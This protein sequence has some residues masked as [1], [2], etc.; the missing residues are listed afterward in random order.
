MYAMSDYRFPGKPGG[1][2]GEIA[3]YCAMITHT[4]APNKPHTTGYKNQEKQKI[5]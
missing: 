5:P 2:A 1:K 3:D 4:D